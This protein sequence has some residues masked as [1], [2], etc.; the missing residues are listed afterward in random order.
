MG[1][2]RFTDEQKA[3]AVGSY[4]SGNKTAAEV[5]EQIGCAKV[6][7]YEWAKQL[8]LRAR[9]K[10]ATLRPPAEGALP[11]PFALPDHPQL[12]T[13]E[14]GADV[15]ANVESIM[16]TL[17]AEVGRKEA[18]LSQLRAEVDGIEKELPRLKAALAALQDP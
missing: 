4:I 8:K 17:V 11:K 18:R 12:V 10:R 9:A 13:E 16:N 15:P 2:P 5:A 6:S 14:T 1:V 7:I 3:E